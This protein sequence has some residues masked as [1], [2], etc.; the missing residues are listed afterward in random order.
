MSKKFLLTGAGFTKNFGGYLADEVGTYMFNECDSQSNQEI[1]DL[2]CSEHDFESIYYKVANTGSNNLISDLNN[3]I[4]SVYNRMDKELC[5]Y[6]FSES[7][8]FAI[9]IYG[10]RKLIKYFFGDMGN[11]GI[12]FTLNQDLFLERHYWNSPNPIV[13]GINYYTD[14]FSP[15]SSDNKNLASPIIVD[16]NIN[17]DNHRVKKPL[18]IKLHG[19]FNWR[20]AENNIVMIIGR[21]KYNQIKRHP[22]LCQ[23]YELFSGSIDTE[24]AKLLIIGYSFSDKHINKAISDAIINSKLSIYIINTTTRKELFDEIGR[25]QYGK[26]IIGAIKKYYNESL[27]AIFPK[28]QSITETCRELESCFSGRY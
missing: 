23:Y 6:C 1:R 19:S 3:I 8:P 15:T 18:Y 25:N 16:S 26:V 10:V 20:S 7:S 27:S 17:I 5:R 28:D 24:G 12:V 21:D 22:L 2:L 4:N 13:P 9:N 14:I 11:P